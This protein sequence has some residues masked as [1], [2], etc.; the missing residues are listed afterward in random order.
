MRMID[1]VPIELVQSSKYK[2]K[3]SKNEDLK[4]ENSIWSDSEVSF[5]KNDEKYVKCTEI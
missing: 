4:V 3:F 2:C 5:M 1:E